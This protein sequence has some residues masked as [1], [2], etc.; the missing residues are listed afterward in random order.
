MRAT[1]PHIHLYHHLGRNRAVHQRLVHL[2]GRTY[3]D[4]L[5]QDI[6]HLYPGSSLSIESDYSRY[7]DFLLLH[8]RRE[9]L[10]THEYLLLFEHLVEKDVIRRRL[11]DQELL[12]YNGEPVMKDI[13]RLKRA[14]EREVD[15]FGGTQRRLAFNEAPIAR[16]FIQ[17]LKSF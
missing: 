14:Y 6:T 2:S 9:L 3:V 8:D 10:I 15:C 12:Y 17:E 16:M 5:E 1:V 4:Q 7:L 11:K 13:A